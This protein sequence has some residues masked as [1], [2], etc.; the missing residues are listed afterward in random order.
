MNPFLFLDNLRMQPD[1]KGQIVHVQDIPPKSAR[2]REP[3][4]PLHDFLA[5]RLGQMGVDHLYTHQALAID[6]VR[7]RRSVVIVT[8]TASG[9][10]MCYNLP[11]LERML[12]NHSATALYLFPT[13]ALAQ[14]QL[15]K[16]G[17]FGLPPRV[18]CGTYD[19]DTPQQDRAYL[20]NRARIILSNV[21]MLHRG[22]LPRHTMWARFLRR[23]EYI[24]IDEIHTYRGVFGS[25]VGCVLRRLRRLCRHYGSDPVFIFCS[26]TIA[27]PSELARNLSGVE[28]TVIDDDGAPSGPRK[29]V[30]WNPPVIGND[31]VRRSAHTEATHLFSDLVEQGIRNITFTKARKSAELILRYAREYLSTHSPELVHRIMSYRAGYKASQRRD[32]ESRLFDGRLLGVVATDALELG[33][34]IGDLDASV[35]TGYPGTISSAW[36]QAGRAG[37]RDDESISL[38]VGMSDPLDQYLMNHP[39]YFFR[40]GQECVL[41]NPSNPYI[42]SHHLACAAY[43]LPLPAE[44]LAEFGEDASQLAWEMT[45]E[46][47]LGY[48]DGRFYWLPEEYPASRVNIRSSSTET[49]RISTED[50]AEVGQIEA[51]RAFEEV[52]EGAI[53]LHAGET[54]RVKKL[55]T[56]AREAVVERGEYGYYTR[57]ADETNLRIVRTDESYPLGQATSYLGRVEVSNRVVAYRRIELF[58]DAIT[59]FDPLDLPELK[60]QT[61]G[62]WWTL[63]HSLV[64]RLEQDDGYELM[65]SIHAIEHAAISL[66]PLLASCDRWDVGGISHQYHLD[67]GGL[68]TIF[69]YDAHPGG[70][71]IATQCYTRL[72][73]L[74]ADTTDL[75]LSCPCENGCPSCIH[76]PKCGNNNSPLDKAGALRLLSLLLGGDSGQS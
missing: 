51:S 75:L 60:Y 7:R 39:D 14:D 49:Y 15:S 66:V 25:N 31:G 59:G 67:T 45:A 55:D 19:G 32:I 1:Y 36:Q 18:V 76:S 28:A 58:T 46:D 48:R 68:A 38:M 64:R 37:R 40:K 73:E 16:L 69:L 12:Q 4:K 13:K 34:D 33:V 54:Y 11:V 2:C 24:V 52:H 30:F 20:R 62:V 50:G 8:G 72:K 3:E 5:E 23:V 6:A 22:I 26:A 42:L 74:L 61:E 56:I 29:F 17:M 63:P 65:G 21:D 41:I 44:D 35:L 43:E 47:M 10:T 53:Y 71:G 9:K 57:T 27:N 70:V